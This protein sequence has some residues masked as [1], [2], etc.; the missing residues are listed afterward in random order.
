MG[1]YSGNGFLS[2]WDFGNTFAIRQ[3]FTD[4]PE[5]RMAT[6]SWE[7]CVPPEPGIMAGQQKRSWPTTGNSCP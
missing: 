2:G 4:R 5:Y 7:S 6:L 3:L 1:P